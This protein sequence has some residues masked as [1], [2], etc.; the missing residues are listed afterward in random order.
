MKTLLLGTQ[1]E[2]K[3]EEAKG[4]L[5]GI[6]GM[7][8]LTLSDRPFSDVEETGNTFLENALLKATSIGQETGLCV[9]SED[10]GLEVAALDGRPGVRSARFAGEPSD[11]A[12]NNQ[13]LLQELEDISDRIARFVTVAAL[14]LADGQLFVT[15]GVFPGSIGTELRGDGGFGY[16][17]L[18]IPD[19]ETRTLAEMG[20]QEKNRISHR[21]RALSRMARI[22]E[23]L[24]ASGEWGSGVQ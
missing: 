18:F 7:E 2:G 12:R 1:N 3:I 24:I 17:P 22:I 9:L 13:R 20:L 15:T 14:R 16:D 23:H 8:L 5:A 21:A 6:A 11:P 10:A 4:L 19:G